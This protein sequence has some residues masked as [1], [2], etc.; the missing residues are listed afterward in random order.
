MTVP[1]GGER[2]IVGLRE[3]DV[4][5]EHLTACRHVEAADDVQQRRL[6]GARGPQQD[7]EL[8]FRELQRYA[9][10][11]KDI[12]IADVIGLRQPVDFEYRCSI[13]GRHHECAAAQR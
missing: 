11:R 6:A 1:I 12:D 4:S 7:D 8:T 5:V 2:R 9:A 10:K 13:V 3:I